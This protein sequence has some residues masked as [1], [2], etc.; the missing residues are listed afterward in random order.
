MI[1]VDIENKKKEWKIKFRFNRRKLRFR[2]F[3]DFFKY[4]ELKLIN[5]RLGTSER[6]DKRS[7]K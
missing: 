7:K 5:F 1:E 6:V 3:E 4:S 2:E